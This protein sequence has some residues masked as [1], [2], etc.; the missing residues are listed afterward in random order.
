M[1]HTIYNWPWAT[2]WAAISAIFTA[3]AV[4]VAAW[5]MMRWRKQDELKVK[6]AFKTAIA[7]YLVSC[8][9]L[10]VSFNN[11]RNDTRLFEQ[12]NK[13]L[14]DF[15]ACRHA[16]WMLEGLLDDDE[17]VKN[18]W[19]FLSDNTNDFVSGEVR[20]DQ[21]LIHCRNILSK[22]FVFK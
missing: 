22:R 18:A 8:V 10:S 1:W 7:E 21:L 6:L 19:N 11:E 15:S 17:I 13:V 12:K 5:A 16:W 4:V 9:T 3:A 14:D 20:V 2:I